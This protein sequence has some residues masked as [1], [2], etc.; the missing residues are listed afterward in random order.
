ML[1]NNGEDVVVVAVHQTLGGLELDAAESEA[2]VLN[3]EEEHQFH[4]LL[5]Y[6]VADAACVAHDEVFLELAELL[7]ADG[8][9]AEGAESSGYAVNGLFLCFHF[10]VQVVAAFVDACDGIVRQGDGV[11]I[12]NDF[13]NAGE[14]ESL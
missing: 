3:L 12:V 8:N 9:V 1:I 6:F 13:L 2:E 4:N 10:F 7:F 11:F 5:R 14:G